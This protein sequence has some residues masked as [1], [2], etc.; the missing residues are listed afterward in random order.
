MFLSPYNQNLPLRSP[1]S[2]FHRERTKSAHIQIIIT[3][4]K[5]Q[6]NDIYYINRLAVTL[7]LGPLLSLT[8][9]IIWTYQDMRNISHTFFTTGSDGFDIGY[10]RK[11]AS[12][13]ILD[14]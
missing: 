7:Y 3:S 1:S 6:V 5:I 9:L 13:L 2:I 12:K 11:A 8:I 4:H 14:Y 10:D